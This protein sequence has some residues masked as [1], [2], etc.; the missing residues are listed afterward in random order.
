MTKL[1]LS[2]S[3]I[4]ERARKIAH[5]S[6]V[7]TGREMNTSKSGKT[8]AQPT[9][10]LDLDTSIYM[11]TEVACTYTCFKAE[12]SN[13]E[14]KWEA[15]T[16]LDRNKQIQTGGKVQ[17]GAP[18]NV[19]SKALKSTTPTSNNRGWSKRANFHEVLAG[20]SERKKRRGGRRDEESCNWQWFPMEI[21][22]QNIRFNV[23]TRYRG[24]TKSTSC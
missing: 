23:K 5:N 3:E 7:T 13:S 1:S 14:G 21:Q 2:W 20:T 6:A 24:R 15:L 8:V 18:A 12:Q 9:S 17:G 19:N 10:S 4:R 22:G 11:E 16:S